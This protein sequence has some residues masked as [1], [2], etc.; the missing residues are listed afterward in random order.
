MTPY[1]LGEATVL[2]ARS[3]EKLAAATPLSYG[4]KGKLYLSSSG[5]LLLDVPNDIGN[6]AFKALDELG[7]EQPL[8]RTKKRYNAHISVMAP[9]EVEAAGGPDKIKERGQTFSFNLGAVRE[10]PN[11]HGQAHLSKAWAIEA[12]SPELLALRRAYDLGAPSFKFHITFATRKRQRRK[13]A[14]LIHFGIKTAAERGVEIKDSAID[15]KGLFA[16]RSYTAGDVIVAQFMTK[17]KGE[18]AQTNYAQSDEA[19]FTNHNGEQNIDLKK[20]DGY[21]SAV[22]A[23]DIASGEE[24]VGNYD[25][26]TTILGPGVY[27]TYRGKRYNGES[28]AQPKDDSEG[29]RHQPPSAIGQLLVKRAEPII[30]PPPNS[31]FAKADSEAEKEEKKLERAVIRNQRER[32]ARRIAASLDKIAAL[33][34]PTEVP[35][36]EKAATDSFYLNAIN[37]TPMNWDEQR[38]VAQNLMGHLQRI[39]ARGNRGIQEAESYDRLQN[40]MDPDRSMRQLSSALSGRRQPLVSHPLD[41]AIHEFG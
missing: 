39:K 27:F 7:I 30:T 15:G 35:T 5:W 16:T 22:A 24:L 11:P 8:S 1:D 28:S 36:T 3:A 13:S 40:A 37:Q 31:L 33:I 14:S 2:L 17:L 19:R 18:D 26:S 25:Q 6:G 38:G 10:I 41:R 23:R 21:V 32:K 12:R 4:M 9:D 34:S 20:V 29:L